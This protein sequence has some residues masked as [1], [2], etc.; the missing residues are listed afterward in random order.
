MDKIDSRKLALLAALG[1]MA[2][3]GLTFI[4]ALLIVC[5][6]IH[7]WVGI[8]STAALLIALGGIILTILEDNERG[9]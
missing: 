5:Y 4:V 9:Y 3:G 6:S 2:L 7:I 8:L 1:A